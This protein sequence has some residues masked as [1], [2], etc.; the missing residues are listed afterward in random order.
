MAEHQAGHPADRH[1]PRPLHPP[2]TPPVIPALAPDSAPGPGATGSRALRW[3]AATA[4]VGALLIYNSVEGSGSMLPPPVTAP[5]AAPAP[6]GTGDAGGTPRAPAPAAPV[7][8]R[9]VPTRLSIPAIGVNAPFVPLAI[10]SSGRLNAP[11]EDDKNLVGWYED[12]PTPGER[13][14][15]IVAGH[16]DTRTGPAVFLMLAVLR[17]GSTAEI[18]RADGRVV[19]FTVDS[20]EN[21]AKDAF[22]DQRVYG[23]TPDAQLRLIT[24][25]GTYDRAR[26]DYRENVVVFAHLSASRPG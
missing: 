19:T 2:S 23:D 26:R 5:A 4:L 1:P 12:G 6:A 24:C 7:L 17:P 10:D 14:N 13:G 21:F 25:G 22:P 16:V 8:A 20:V 18:T 3:A 11:P 9:S 15:A